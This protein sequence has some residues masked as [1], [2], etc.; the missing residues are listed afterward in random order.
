[1]KILLVQ[2]YVDDIIF[3]SINTTLAETFSSL[4]HTVFEMSMIGELLFF[5]E[6]QVKQLNDDI[7]ISQTK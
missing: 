2:I 4:M 3:H 5:L 7:F 6:F 1:M